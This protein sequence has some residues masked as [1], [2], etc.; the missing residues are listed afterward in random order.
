VDRKFWGKALTTFIKT[1][2]I[3]VRVYRPGDPFYKFD[4][5]QKFNEDQK[6]KLRVKYDGMTLS[7]LAKAMGDNIRGKFM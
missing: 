3:F 4:E 5:T 1:Q 2:E 7:E 6:R